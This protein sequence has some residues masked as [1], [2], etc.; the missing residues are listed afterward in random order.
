MYRKSKSL[1]HP[2]PAAAPYWAKNGSFLVYRRLRQN[3][4]GF[5]RFL[6]AEAA[7][8]AQ[9]PEFAGLNTTLGA[10]LV[11]RWRSGAPFLR[12]PC[13]DL[14]RLG[15]MDGA[16]NAFSFLVGQESHDEFPPAIADPLG[17]ICPQAAHIRKVNPRDVPTDQGPP[18]TTLT[19]RILRRGIPYGPPLSIGA[20]DDSSKED[21]GLLFLC[22]QAS[23]RDQFEFLMGTWMNDRSKPSPFSPPGGSGFDMVVGQNPDESQNRDRFCLVG[24]SKARI[25]TAGHAARQWVIP[26]GGGYFFT[27]S[28]SAIR[29]VLMRL[30]V[31]SS[32]K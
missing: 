25:S 31:I 20:T 7:R 3:V 32:R 17:T 1:F 30:E 10:M 12:S 11:G 14:D 16:N 19:Q 8:L 15:S 18:N 4:S 5:N 9:T 21:R 29:D 28:R 26:T 22:Y 27:P 23:I 6:E 2:G 24:S 13:Q